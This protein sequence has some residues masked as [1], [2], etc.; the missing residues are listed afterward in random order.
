LQMIDE[1][2]VLYRLHQKLRLVTFSGDTV[3]VKAVP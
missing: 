1:V 2:S 3:R